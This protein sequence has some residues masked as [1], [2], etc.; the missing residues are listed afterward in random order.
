MINDNEIVIVVVGS[1]NFDDY[2][3]FEEKMYEV[4]GKYFEE[5]IKITIKEQESTTTDNFVVRFCKENNCNLER[6]KINWEKYGKAAA[7]INNKILIF[8]EDPNK[9]IPSEFPII[10][11]TKKDKEKD[12]LLINNLLELFIECVTF[13]NEITTPKY[14]IFEK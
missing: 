4:L 10:F 13:G 3:F 6:V 5:D 14:Y 9:N 2:T 11:L 7:Y 12:L 1:K 8:G